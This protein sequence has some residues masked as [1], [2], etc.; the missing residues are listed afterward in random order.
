LQ[1]DAPLPGP[2]WFVAMKD[3]TVMDRKVELTSG[4][5]LGGGRGGGKPDQQVLRDAFC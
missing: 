5:D 2:H 1:F 4:E 3:R